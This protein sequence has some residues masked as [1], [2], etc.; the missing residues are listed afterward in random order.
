MTTSSPGSSSVLNTTLSAPPAPHV[1]ITPSAVKGRP[2]S[3]E[4][5]AA[6][7]ALVSGYPAFGMY[8]CRPGVV[9]SASRRSSRANS[10]GGSTSGLPSDRS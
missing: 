2:V 7:A 10:G 5:W 9:S 1:M 6:T 3:A 8:R 4:S